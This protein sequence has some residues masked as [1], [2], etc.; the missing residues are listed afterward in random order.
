MFLIGSFRSRCMI[1]TV[2]FAGACS[3]ADSGATSLAG[4]D[5]GASPDA[6]AGP[7]TTD[8][9]G[10]DAG[11]DANGA[12]VRPSSPAQ[13]VDCTAPLAPGD[14]RTC[15]LEV[16]GTPR[17]FLLYAPAR[18]DPCSGTALFVDAH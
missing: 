9:A 4:A 12:C 13:G 15:T 3:S 6:G 14:E 11:G 18:Y 5:G 17:Q 2:A 10:V 16:N 7:A 1:A 8:D